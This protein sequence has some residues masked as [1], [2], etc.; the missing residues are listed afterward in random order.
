MK[1]YILFAVWRIDSKGREGEGS[2]PEISG[3]WYSDE[4]AQKARTD[5]MKNSEVVAAWVLVAPVE[6]APA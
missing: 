5:L 1:V 6:G 3:V 2:E 4:L